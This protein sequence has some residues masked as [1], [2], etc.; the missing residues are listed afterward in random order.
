[1]KYRNDERVQALIE[2]L[3]LKEE[4]I[5]RAERAVQGISRDYVRAIRRM[6]IIKNE[7]DRNQRS[8]DEGRDEGLEEGRAEG[9]AEKLEIARKMKEAGDPIEKIHAIT[10]LSFET[11]EQM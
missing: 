7:M 10:G 9:Y 5:M 11:L 4:G 8:Y 1:M 6:N 2:E 3:C